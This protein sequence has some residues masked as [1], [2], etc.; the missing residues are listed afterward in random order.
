MNTSMNTSYTLEQEDYD[1][2]VRS[3]IP[4][5]AFLILSCIFGTIGNVHVFLV[6]LLRYKANMYKKLVLCLTAVDFVGCTFCIPASLYIIRN[7]YSVQSSVF[8]KLYFATMNLVGTLSLVLL[9]GIAVERYRKICQ[10]TPTHFSQRTTRVFCGLILVAMITL[11]F[12]PSFFM[13]GIN[14]ETTKVHSLPSYRCAVSNHLRNSTFVHVYGG[15]LLLSFLINLTISI[16]SYILIGRRIYIHQ[17]NNMA[18]SPQT[19]SLKDTARDTAV[20]SI[21]NTMNERKRKKLDKS[22]NTIKVFLVVSMIS[23]GV[24]LPYLLTAVIRNVNQRLY[25]NFIANYG[26]LPYFI[27]WMIFLNNAINPLVYGFM[28]K[29]FRQELS[30]LYIQMKLCC[31]ACCRRG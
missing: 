20:S 19:T 5:T 6:Y 17:K 9:N 26:P 8:C 2:F 28:D 11:F 22:R 27:T 31:F 15:F 3:G 29:K 10:K 1:E 16:V 21:P 14:Q 25:Q 7:I 18:I 30:A 12:I 13:F 4:I 23:F 24:Y